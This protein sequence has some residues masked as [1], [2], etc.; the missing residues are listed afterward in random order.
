MCERER[1]RIHEVNNK[2]RRRIRDA[3]RDLR[4][5]GSR[6][7]IDLETKIKLWGRQSGMCPCCLQVIDRPTGR[8]DD[9]QG[10][11]MTPL[12]KGGADALE[13]LAL[14]HARCNQDKFNKT[15]EEHWAWRVKCR[16]DTV[17]LG[18]NFRLSPDSADFLSRLAALATSSG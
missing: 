11:H 10:D 2:D 5:G 6:R 8:S 15:L 3:E 13:N 17:N 9:G 7:A 1:S 4:Q 16:Y 18:D 14:T 12:S